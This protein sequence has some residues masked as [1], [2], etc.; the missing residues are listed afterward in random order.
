MYHRKAVAE[1]IH[2]LRNRSVNDSPW[3]LNGDLYMCCS[4]SCL[5]GAAEGWQPEWPVRE[6]E[7]ERE[8][9]TTT[10]PANA[11]RIYC[12]RLVTV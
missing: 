12:E 1:Q 10:H 9:A 2:K 7:S 4:M 11:H 6:A 3:P 5:K 8:V